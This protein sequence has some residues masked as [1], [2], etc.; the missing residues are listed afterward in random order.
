MLERD[1]VGLG[2]NRREGRIGGHG[3]KMVAATSHASVQRLSCLFES[4]AAPDAT[5]LTSLTRLRPHLLLP[6]IGA[7]AALLLSAPA[8]GAGTLTSEQVALTGGGIQQSPAIAVDPDAPLR[9]A[10]VADDGSAGGPFPRTTV[11]SSTDWS[12]GPWPSSSLAHQGPSNSAG[13]PDIAWGIDHTGPTTQKVYL[14][15][16]ASGSGGSLCTA[17]N[18]GIFFSSSDDGGAHWD[19]ALQASSGSAF[20][21]AIEPAIAADRSTGRVYVAYTRLDYSTMGCTGAPDSSQIFMLYSDNDGLSWGTGARRVSPL[22][23]SGSAHFRSPSLAVLPDGRVIVAFRDDSKAQIETE[24]CTT[25]TPPSG[26]YC[27]SSAGFVGPS[28][29]VGDATSPAVVSGVAGAPA[30]SVVAAGG[31]VTVAWHANAP[32]GVRAFAAMSRDG[33]ATFGPAQQIDPDAPGNQVAPRLAATANGRVDVAYLWDTSGTGVVSATTAS[34]APPLP[35]ATAEAWGNPVIVQAVGAQAATGIPGIA[36]LG[37]RLGV[38]T[39]WVPMTT[40]LSPLPATVVAFTDSSGAG[41]TQDVHVVGLL[42]GTTAPVI[43]AQT[44]TASKNVSTIVHVDATDADGDPLTWSTGAQPTTSGSSVST[45][46]AARGEFAFNAA[47]VVGTDTFEAVA[48]DGVPGHEARA[49][50]T[51]DVVNDP[52]KVTC[53]TLIAV[54]NTPRPIQ[55]SECASDPNRDPVSISLDGATGGT[56]ERT[57]GTWY[58]VPTHDST[59]AGS[60]FLRASD[61]DK[62]SLPAKVS[63][64]IVSETGPV[65]LD[66]KN[67][68]KTLRIATGM[69]VR[70]TGSAVDAAGHDVGITWDFGDHTRTATGRWVS[71]RFRAPGTFTVKAGAGTAVSKIKV[72]VRRRAV[73]LMGVP[74]VFDGVLQLRVRTREAGTLLLRADSRS[75]TM[76]VPAGLTDRALAIQVTTGPLVRLTLRLTPSKKSPGLPVRSVR[77]LVMVSPLSGG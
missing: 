64:T 35:G 53:S 75:H 63:V 44:V 43:A 39:S 10:V 12:S 55:V 76:T 70:M 6:V 41:G 66:V 57:N 3:R 37:R 49:M 30:P 34:A 17:F 48:A 29:V 2:G 1:V 60:F 33:G 58:F 13:Q 4:R 50:V 67:A 26:N 72:V 9:A 74:Q 71:H 69:A 23:T 59:A 52:P 42:H 77:R 31:R 68:G 65:H 47:N 14:V 19:T 27:G 18:S 5:R 7:A 25:P 56:V 45:A 36:P 8:L 62:S 20:T 22:A 40:P 28:T 73:E 24:T 54:K 16:D 11:A 51:V 15:E 21:Q 38:A 61:G 46:D 32:N